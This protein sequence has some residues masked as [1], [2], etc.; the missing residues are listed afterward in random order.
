MMGSYSGV[1]LICAILHI[2]KCC[3]MWG[4]ISLPF[5]SVLPSGHLAC[6]SGCPNC[7][8]NRGSP[9]DIVVQRPVYHSY[10]WMSNVYVSSSVVTGR[11]PHC[12]CHLYLSS[13]I[14]GVHLFNSLW[15]R[16]QQFE[17]TAWCWQRYLKLHLSTLWFSAWVI[18]GPI[19]SQ[20]ST[21]HRHP[22]GAETIYAYIRHIQYQLRKRCTHRPVY[23]C[24]LPQVKNNKQFFFKPCDSF[25]YANLHTPLPRNWHCRCKMAIS[26]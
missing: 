1:V 6:E 22:P 17:E 19:L 10:F 3:L 25:R 11:W 9:L 23:V 4:S 13:I 5:Y 26:A 20:V 7:Y 14:I 21:T 15:K 2:E 12:L 18:Y 8:A 24:K 16:Y